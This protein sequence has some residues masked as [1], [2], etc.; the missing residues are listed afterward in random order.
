MTCSDVG[1]HLRNEVG[2]VAGTELLASACIVA[3]F[4]LKAVD[5]ADAHTQH[6]A[7]TILVGLLKVETG[8]LDCLS[9]CHHG[10]LGVEVHLVGLLAVDILLGIEV[11]YFTCEVSL[12]LLGIEVGDGGCA[13]LACQDGGPCVGYIVAQGGDGTH[14]CNDYSLKFHINLY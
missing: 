8:V 2:A 6:Y 13:A 4:L 12:K 3:H 9:G 1:N 5:T 7:D 10:I 14:A 11:F